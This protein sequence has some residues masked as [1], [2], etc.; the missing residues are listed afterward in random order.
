MSELQLNDK[1]TGL[2]K[3]KICRSDALVNLRGFP[4]QGFFDVKGE[5][6]WCWIFGKLKY[7]S[8][9]QIF[10]GRIEEVHLAMFNNREI[11]TGRSD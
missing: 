10:G 6:K 1:M 9:W 2:S 11:R 5:A 4:S 7:L 3:W 8:K